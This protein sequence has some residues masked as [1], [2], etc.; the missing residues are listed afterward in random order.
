MDNPTPKLKI[1]PAQKYVINHLL[2]KFL[3]NPGID[4]VLRSMTQFTYV[5]N[6]C[7]LTL[8]DLYS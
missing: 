7:A 6:D 5:D 4:S 3:G 8:V 2:K 1:L